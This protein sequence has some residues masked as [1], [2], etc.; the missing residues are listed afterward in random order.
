MSTF[1]YKNYCVKIE[2]DT[3]KYFAGQPDAV[4]GIY[5]ICESSDGAAGREVY[6]GQTGKTFPSGAAAEIVAASE[7]DARAWID[8]NAGKPWA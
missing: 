5:V 6:R 7:A 2:T 1:G 3:A 8:V 4:R